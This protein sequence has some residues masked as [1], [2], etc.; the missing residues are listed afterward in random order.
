MS[1]KQHLEQMSVDDLIPLWNEWCAQYR[2]DDAIYDSIEEFAE[3]Y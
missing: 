3:L 1:F 2:Q